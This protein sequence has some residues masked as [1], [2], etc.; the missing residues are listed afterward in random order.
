MLFFQVFS[1]FWGVVFF[2]GGNILWGLVGCC[3]FFMFF[4]FSFGT[5][6]CGLAFCFFLRVFDFL[7][8]L[9]NGQRCHK[10]LKKTSILKFR[11]PACS[12]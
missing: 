4:L 8:H 12:Q 11:L 6:G 10:N 3:W 5:F 1:F 2:W 7:Q 9:S